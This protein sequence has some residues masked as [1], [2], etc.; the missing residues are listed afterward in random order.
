VNPSLLNGDTCNG[1]LTTE[2]RYH[3]ASVQQAEGDPSTPTTRDI[4][5]LNDSHLGKCLIKTGFLATLYLDNSINFPDNHRSSRLKVH[6]CERPFEYLLS[7]T[8]LNAIFSFRSENFLYPGFLFRA[9]A[10]L[11]L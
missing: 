9:I 8:R 10:S 1:R 5:R 2:H 7:I 11:D 3:A 6:Y 4:F